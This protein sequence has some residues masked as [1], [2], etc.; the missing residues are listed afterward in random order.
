MGSWLHRRRNKFPDGPFG[1]LQYFLSRCSEYFS[2]LFEFGINPFV[3]WDIIAPV[4][5]YLKDQITELFRWRRESEEW[6]PFFDRLED[7]PTL[8]IVLLISDQFRSW[9][10]KQP[11]FGYLFVVSF[12]FA[13]VYYYWQW[14][15]HHYLVAIFVAIYCSRLLIWCPP[16]FFVYCPFLI[17][18]Y[19]FSLHFSWS[20][21]F[22][23]CHFVR[24]TLE[25]L[26]L[27]VIPLYLIAA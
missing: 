16:L 7:S 19:F 3:K 21:F 23:I 25:F 12:L 1:Q 5:A 9:A 20:I 11:I 15:L 4:K 8:E 6:K 10:I 27:I 14:C 13:S 2:E 17:L 26:V 18:C 22:G 24:K